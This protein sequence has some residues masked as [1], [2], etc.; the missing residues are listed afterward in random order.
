MELV[1]TLPLPHRGL[2]PNSLVKWQVRYGLTKQARERAKR[3]TFKLIKEIDSPVWILK[4]F[5]VRAYFRTKR[6]W[7]RTNILSSLKAVEDGISD[8][9]GQ[10]DVT[11]EDTKIERFTDTKNPRLEILLEIEEI[12]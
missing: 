6:M 7:D 10:N 9:V 3:E 8:A 11:F 5:H 12:V 2:R 1:L 4:G